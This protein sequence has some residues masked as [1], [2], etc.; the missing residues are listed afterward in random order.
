[1]YPEL[2]ITLRKD[3]KAAGYWQ[4]AQGGSLYCV[5]IRGALS[6][7]AVDLL[8]IDDPVKDRAAAESKTIR[9]A[10]WDWWEN[11]AKVRA[12]RTLVIQTRWHTDDLSGRLL[13]R[14]GGVGRS[15]RSPRSPRTTTTRSA[16]RSARRW[17]RP[18]SAAARLL[19][20]AAEDDVALRVVVAV[21][22]AADRGGRRHLQAG[23]LAVL[24]PGRA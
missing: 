9:D 21:P 5:G 2:G 17:S 23:R 4:T 12:M 1:V 11:V 7:R 15:C 20:G 22:A 18:A 3:S 6:S 24:G 10:T 13:E 19:L 14:A 8:I 16:A